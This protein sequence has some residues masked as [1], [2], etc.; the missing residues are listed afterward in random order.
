[1]CFKCYKTYFDTSTF[2]ATGNCTY[3]CLFFHGKISLLVSESM[4]VRIISTLNIQ[5]TEKKKNNRILKLGCTVVHFF[6]V[7]ND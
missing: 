6:L 2:Q 1:M 3:F 7:I 5:E 4:F